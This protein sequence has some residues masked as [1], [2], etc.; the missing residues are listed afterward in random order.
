MDGPGSRH[1]QSRENTVSKTKSTSDDAL[2]VKSEFMFG[3]DALKTGFDKT[4]KLCKNV[5]EFNKDTL[6]AYIESATVAGSGLQ[7]VAQETSSYA[8]Q[9]IE[10]AIAASK[11]MMG[12]KSINDMVE[13]QTSFAK[14][15]FSGYVGHLSRF[16]KTLVSAAK[17]SC[18]PLQA[19]VEAA[20]ELIQSTPT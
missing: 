13:I 2:P 9:A 6:E 18:A 16:N 8:K 5:G 14:T 19:R 12:S 15:A 7:S 17:Q 10:D 3:V 1:Q 20:A 4:A 11:A